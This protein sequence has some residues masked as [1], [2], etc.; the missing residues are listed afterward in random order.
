MLLRDYQ[1]LS[2]AQLRDGFKAGLRRQLL[3]SPTGSGKTVIF[4]YMTSEASRRGLRV[5]VLAHR[6]EILDQIEDTLRLFDVK[7]GRIRAGHGM[8]ITKS[9]MVAS[10]QT[11]VRR[12]DQ[13]PEPD[14]V[15]VDEAA[16]SAANQWVRVFAQ[17]PKAKFVGVTATPERLDGKGLGDYYEKMVMGPSVQWLMDQGFLK[18]PVYY[19]PEHGVDLSS[20]K[21]MAGDYSKAEL[22]KVMDK[23]AITGDAV[24]HYR[25]LGQGMPAVAF[26]VN[27]SHAERVA[28]QFNQSGI[29]AEL[30]DGTMTHDQRRERKARLASG[31][32]KIMVSVDLV[33]EGFDLPAVGVA[34][35]LRPTASLALHLQQVGRA[36]RRSDGFPTAVI[37]DHAGNCVRHGL[38]EEE[39]EWSLEGHAAKKRRKEVA[40]ETRQCAKCYAIF[41]GTLCP[42]CGTERESKVREI[43]Q[44]AGELR[45]LKMGEHQMAMQRRMEEA[46]CRSFDDWKA[47]EKARSYK[48]GWAIFRWKNSRHYQQRMADPGIAK[49]EQKLAQ[50]ALAV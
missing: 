50:E 3:T 49:R 25:R 1:N 27:L 23:N 9:V 15:I 33:S 19:A 24:D 16:H 48:N 35:L 29:T 44:R 21:K 12:L 6:A 31:A 10:V 38:A 40:L 43:E 28:E 30:I 22:G 26:C 14:L 20:V 46:K 7:F 47:I 18:R 32:T 39:R 4:A 13:V 34:I 2:V 8:D 37:L 36:L 41:K 5:L 42:Q 45:E 11:L 17:Y